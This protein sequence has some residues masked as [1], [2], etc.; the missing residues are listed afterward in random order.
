MR[1]LLIFLV[2]CLNIKA[3]DKPNVLLISIDDLNDWVGYLGG[4]PQAITPIMDT[5][6]KR[7]VAFT[8]AH[9]TSPLC[10]PSR[11]SLLSGLREEKTGIF[12]NNQKFDLKKHVLLPQYFAK[13][14]YLTYGT[15]KIHHQKKNN[16]MFQE[17][18]HPEQ[19]WSPFQKSRTVLYAKDELPSKGSD[20][21]R[22]VIKNGPGGRDYVLPFNRMASDRAPNRNSGESFDWHAF[23]LEDNDFGEGLVTEW[24]IEKLKKHDKNKPFFM[25]LGY[26][27]P[28]IPLYAP[29]K[30]FDMYPLESVKLPEILEN[31]LDDLPPIAKKWAVDAVTAGLHSS[32]LKHSQWKKAVQAYLACVTFVDAQI[33]KILEFLDESEYGKNTI[34]VL[35]SDHGWQLGEKQHW[36]KWT[37]WNNSTR[38][39]FIIIPAG[40]QAN[41]NCHE[42]VSLLDIYPTLVEMAGLPPKSLDGVSLVN[43]LN[44]PQ[45]NMERVVRTIFD[46]G[47]KALISKEWRYIRYSDGSEELYNRL[48][49]P[50][51]FHN[52]AQK[53]EYIEFLEKMR[54]AEYR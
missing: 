49:D 18:Y 21:P 1:V 36:G 10:N 27:R 41:K 50:H 51:E 52:L 33:G 44:A 6:A 7:G 47:N 13:N 29:K 4:H 14:G 24:A 15:G 39:P 20:N 32:T 34:I 11:S 45:K 22:H 54:K 23:D 2:I 48:K 16:I 28:H 8:D 46:Q 40:A 37:G 3:A 31:D 17:S 42:P 26:Y 43:L 25:G 53:A 12:N 30:Y 35:F 19:R 5:L 38:V 9:C